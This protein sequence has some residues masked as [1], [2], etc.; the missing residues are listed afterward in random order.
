[1]FLVKHKMVLALNLI[2]KFDSILSLNLDK[3][4][5][6]DTDYPEEVKT[7][8]EERKKSR[9]DKDYAKSDELRDKIKEYWYEVKD[10]RE[11]QILKKI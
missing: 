11:G 3:E 6:I 5:S 1:M 8:L 2:M 7:L 4:S 9:E 10:T